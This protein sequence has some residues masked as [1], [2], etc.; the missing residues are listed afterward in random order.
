MG[1]V[2]NLFTA[3]NEKDVEGMLALVTDDV[4]WFHV[5][6]EDMTVEASGRDA[7]R[8]AMSRY[9]ADL[10]SAR[11]A[12]R[13]ISS[14]GPFVHTVERASWD[15]GGEEK[16]QCS[17]ALYEIDGGRVRNVWYFPAYSCP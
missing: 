16:S 15:A 4:R 6:E 10:P 17:T 1:V 13:R 9:F 5:S 3:F 11:S 7:L 8:A 12:I 14:S 2:E